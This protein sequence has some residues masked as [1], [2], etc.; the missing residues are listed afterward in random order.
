MKAFCC[1]VLTIISITLCLFLFGCGNSDI[2][3]P[4]LSFVSRLDRLVVQV[5]SLPPPSPDEPGKMDQGIAR[6]DKL[7]GRTLDPNTLP[8]SFRQALDDYLICTFG[9]PATPSIGDHP[10]ATRLGLTPN[11]LSLGSKLYRKHC[12]QCHNIAGDG[13]GPA[14]QFMIPFPR[15]FRQGQFKFISTLNGKPRRID[16]HHVLDEGLKGTQMPSFS[17]LSEFDR[18][19]LARYVI[20]LSIRG[21]VE[22]D[23]LIGI[24][25][26]KII[27]STQVSR[28][29]NDRLDTILLEWEQAEM[30]SLKSTSLQQPDDGLPGSPQHN[31]AVRRGHA[32]FITPGESSCISCHVNYGRNSKLRFDIWG[33]VARP[34]NIYEPVLKGGNR[35]EDVYHR[36]R[37]GIPPVG[38]PPHP[39]LSDRQIWDLVR[40][41]LAVP[42]PSH[43]P[44]DIR[45]VV[46][47]SP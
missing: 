4:T 7:G 8:V 27:D 16:L 9:S 25:T 38:M 39:H 10:I 43:L 14:G 22:F 37:W 17:L 46:Y 24:G 1:Y 12:L 40:F 2:H 33:T 3:P 32:L 28:F 19:S 30:N 29:A 6:V 34:A 35:P 36:I 47:P 45:N 21:Q 31:D 18:D 20:Y 41:V 15:D 5:P 13:R 11:G 42:Y 44:Q 23:T 26:G